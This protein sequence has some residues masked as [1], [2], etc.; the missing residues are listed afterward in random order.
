MFC[1]YVERVRQKVNCWF[2][3]TPRRANFSS[4]YKKD[5]TYHEFNVVT[6]FK[7]SE[8]YAYLLMTYRKFTGW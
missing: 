3:A 1:K 2:L 4:Q 5:A 6:L 8:N 7:R